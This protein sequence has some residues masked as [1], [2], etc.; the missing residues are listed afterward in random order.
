[1]EKKDLHIRYWILT[2]L[3]YT[4]FFLAL[5]FLMKGRIYGNFTDGGYIEKAQ[6]YI[7]KRNTK[8]YEDMN[9]TFWAADGTREK[10]VTAERSHTGGMHLLMEA[11]LM[12]PGPEGLSEGLITYIPVDTELIGLTMSDNICFVAL[13]KEFLSSSDMDRAYTQIKNTLSAGHPGMRVAVIVD[14]EIVIS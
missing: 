5:F 10:I 8:V 3:S 13:S 7:E 14:G 2:V 11:L 1:M 4:A 12:G 9:V 6:A